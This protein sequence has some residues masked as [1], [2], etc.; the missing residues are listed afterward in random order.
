MIQL[1]Y[2]AKQIITDIQ[3]GRT[4]TNAE[5]YK[6]YSDGFSKGVASTMGSSNYGSKNFDLQQ[7]LIASTNKFAAAKA[8]KVTRLIDRQ[9]ADGNGVERSSRDYRIAAAKLLAQFEQ[10]HKTEVATAVARTRT[11]KQFAEFADSDRVRLF[12]NLRWLPSRSANPRAEHAIFYDRVW[13]KDDPFWATN[14]PGTEWN[15]KCDVEET[16]D[17]ATDNKAA[18]GVE[19]MPGLKGNPY[20]TGQIFSDDAKYYR[21][22]STAGQKEC[23][24][25]I[26][27][28]L[29]Q[30][31]KDNLKGKTAEHPELS[32]KIHFTVTGIKEYIDQPFD[33]FDIKNQLVKCLP[34]IIKKSEYKGTTNHKGRT[35]HIFEFRLLDRKAFLIANE[36]KSTDILFYSVTDSEKVLQNIKK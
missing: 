6:H 35:S 2:S 10:Y 23:Y 18:R 24:A 26:R 29:K 34:D 5:L 16:A 13:A 8:Y 7:Q 36:Y 9:K 17:D 33:N 11:A 12:P 3:N 4:K 28:D 27:N 32:Q 22:I 21:G 20:Y 14:S 1:K 25:A 30:W 15:C 31:A 19:P